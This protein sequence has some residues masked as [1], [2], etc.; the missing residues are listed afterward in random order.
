[1]TSRRIATNEKTLLDQDDGAVAAS[2]SSDSSIAPAVPASV[3]IKLLGFT[4]A[5]IALPIGSYFLT[6]NTIF[7]GNSTLA[8]GLAA[9]M[10]NV[11]LIA[12]V[13][14]AFKEDQSERLE[15]ESKEKKSR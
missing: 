14:V 13:V 8:G 6:V 12:Y 5:M 1:M 4:L 2:S 11:V 7:G 15:A 3:I 9:V 10:A